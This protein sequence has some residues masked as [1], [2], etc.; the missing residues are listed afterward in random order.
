MAPPAGGT[1][2]EG[3]Q[4]GLGLQGAQG[5]IVNGQLSVPSLS[6][7]AA[8]TALGQHDHLFHRQVQTLTVSHCTLRSTILEFLKAFKS[9]TFIY[10]CFVFQNHAHLLAS[11]G[12]WS[13]S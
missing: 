7:E 13:M 2:P 5:S 1:P 11:V 10:F 12:D 9:F 4:G 6:T 8:I 3:A